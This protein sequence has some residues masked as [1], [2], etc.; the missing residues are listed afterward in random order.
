M[1]DALHLKVLGA[2]ALLGAGLLVAG[3][4]STPDLT[5]TQAQAL[6]QA[7]YDQ[8]PPAG[9]VIT[10]DKLGMRMG[11]TDGYW[12]LTKVYPN[13]FWADYTLTD[14]GKKALTPQGGG[15]TIQWRPL[16]ADDENY[17]VLITTVVQNHLKARDLRNL[18]DETLPGVDTAKGATYN[19]SVDLTG[20]PGPL[21]DIAHNP[22]NKLST[23]RTAD[24][25]LANGVW[26]LHGIN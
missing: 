13:K 1:K 24:F 3:C 4:K 19:E 14:D 26:K 7:K 2:V 12:K 21:Q 5:E 6:I 25:E 17:T 20:V 22:G 10:V 16:T 9:I 18:H 15:D 11:I 8:D 23:K